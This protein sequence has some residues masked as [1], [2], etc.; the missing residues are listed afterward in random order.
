MSFAPSFS[1]FPSFDSFNDSGPIRT[2]K[3]EEKEKPEKKKKEKGRSSKDKERNRE[4]Q[5]SQSQFKDNFDASLRTK[6]EEPTDYYYSD[7]TGDSG[8][9]QY[10][11]L[12]SSVVP[13]Y[14]VVNR[15]RTI[16][17]LS[18]TP[19]YRS[20]VSMRDQITF[21]DRSRSLD[22]LSIPPRR[23][24]TADSNSSKYQEING[25][26]RLGQARRPRTGSPSYRSIIQADESESESGSIASQ[27]S[28]SNDARTLTS[29]EETLKS[30]EQQ[31]SVD[32]SSIKNWLRLLSQTLSTTIITAKNA[33]KS[34]SDQTVSI[35]SHALS[36]HSANATSILLRIK[37]L[38]A[39]DEVLTESACSS[40]WETALKLGNVDIWMEWF[41]WQIVK[42]SDGLDG[43][44]HAALRI[45]SSLDKSEDSELG[46]LRVFWRTAI[47]FQQ[48][49]YHER[50]IAMFQAQAEFAFAAPQT[51]NGLSFERR[52]EDFE[53]FWD[54]ECPRIGE[55]H[56]KGWSHWASHKQEQDPVSTVTASVAP[57]SA[58]LDPY[59]QWAE[60]ES[61]ADRAGQL[62]A[63]TV[64]DNANDLDSDPYSIVLFA[65]IRPF[66]LDLRT[67]R[68]KSVFRLAWLSTLGLHIPGFSA[69]LSS[70]G[71]SWDDRWSY[72]HLT[73]PAFLN[74]ILPAT[75]NWHVN[76]TADAL[77]GAIIG[78]QKVYKQS[79]GPVKNWSF[80]S[81][82]LFEPIYGSTGMWNTLDI[83]DVDTGFVNR[84]FSSLRFGPEDLDWDILS[85]TFETASSVK[86]ALK[87][88]RSFLATARD[89]LPRWAVHA[90]LERIRGRLDD[91]RKVY[92]TILIASAEPV[93]RSD[94]SC[95]WWEWAEMEWLA[96]QEEPALSVILRAARVEGRGGVAVLRSKRT[97]E[98][99]S[100]VC[101]SW[102]EREAWIKLGALLDILTSHNIQNALSVFDDQLIKAKDIAHESLTI[103]CLIFV[104]RY[105]SVLK[106]TVPPSILRERVIQ[107]MARYPHNSV[108]LA[109]FLEV[110]KGQGVWG[111]IRGTLGDNGENMKDV[112][113]RVQEVWIAGWESGRWE[114]EIERIR[115]GLSGAVEHE[116]TRGCSQI[117]RIYIEIEIRAK[118]YK[119]A[120]GLL[121][122]AIK[123]CP[124]CKDLYLLAFGP[125]RGVFEGWELD[126]LAETMAGR[127]IR[128]RKGLDDILEEWGPGIQKNEEEA[129][130]NN[131]DDEIEYNAKELRRLRP[132]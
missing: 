101:G 17:G 36:A 122:Q 76:L 34:R 109:L 60:Y 58:E 111:R 16:L 116:R 22:L 67:Q 3:P 2:R 107:A 49:G 84:V 72:I 124:R 10:G 130:N 126:A 113:R 6:A 78:R 51:L 33:R 20:Q 88:S 42:S 30:L 23:M 100:Q 98:E 125:L 62:P 43:V 28:S 15:G 27:S 74:T 95:L 103:A 73:K 40:E 11:K 92:Q 39:I 131:E 53:E 46:K 82:P 104:Y 25:F 24:L 120:R 1:S 71:D 127:G 35:L 66:L 85:V 48:A 68:A 41:E 8:N 21:D 19:S 32:P 31:L 118:Q 93:P 86:S 94:E 63:R 9:I 121:L 52:L 37:Y 105:G 108:I 64:N 13:K 54:S 110:E 59:R 106:N 102:R 75:D 114:A 14:F 5:S 90:Q 56:S 112:A 123:Q 81:F 97:L 128:M 65:D 117:W 57:K 29:H 83:T 99:F 96:G 18:P 61:R 91:A 47:V 50:A 129:F 132:Y 7:R 26:L 70:S 80:G 115:I 79:F 119:Q 38:R 55:L 89:S 77:A 69:S 45:L 44:I 87:L 4:R 12:S